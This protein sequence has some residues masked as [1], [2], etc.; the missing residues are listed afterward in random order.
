MSVRWEQERQA[1]IATAQAMASMGLTAGT[2]GNVSVRLRSGMHDDGPEYGEDLV[3]ITPTGVAY[4]VLKPRDIV[5]VDLE[6]EPVD[7]DGIPSSETLLH[8]EIYQRRPDAG[9]VIHTHSVFATVAAV[10]GSEIPAIIDEAIILIGGPVEVSEYAFP[11]SQELAENVCAALGKRNAAIIRN[12]GAVCV[13]A[14]LPEAL[15]VCELLERLAQIHFYAS[16][17]GK[18]GTLP[19]EVVGA[20]MDIF[21]MRQHARLHQS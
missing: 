1:V 13:G 9:A 3:A 2:S 8:T 18:V 19:A 6:V 14:D 12:H 4:P 5:V 7:G 10:T 11:G 21:D 20:E 16:L 17:S 15:N